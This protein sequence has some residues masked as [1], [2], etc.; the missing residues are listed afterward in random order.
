[1][2]PPWRSAKT[3]ISMWR[4]RS[5]NFSSSLEILGAVHAPDAL[6]AAACAR[7][8]EQRPADARGLGREV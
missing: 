5:M 1:M 8:D 3:W 6:A 2:Q 7:L 4:G